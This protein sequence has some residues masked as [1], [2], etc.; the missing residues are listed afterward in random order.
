MNMNTHIF[1]V[2]QQLKL[3]FQQKPIQLGRWGVVYTR[4]ALEKRIDLANI[5]HCGPC[6]HKDIPMKLIGDKY[7]IDSAHF[8]SSKIK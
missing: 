8:D 4:D 6:T 3:L 1:R 7:K 2:T 5:D